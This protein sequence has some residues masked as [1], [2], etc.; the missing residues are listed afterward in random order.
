MSNNNRKMHVAKAKTVDCCLC[1]KNIQQNECMLI[2]T[3]PRKY[4]CKECVQMHK[5]IRTVLGEMKDTPNEETEKKILNLGMDNFFNFMHYKMDSDPNFNKCMKEYMMK[6]P[7][8][9]TLVEKR[10]QPNDQNIL[11]LMEKIMG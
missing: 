11:S 1:K 9:S 3:D 10:D 2:D 7:R 4:I 5:K 6:D 8:F